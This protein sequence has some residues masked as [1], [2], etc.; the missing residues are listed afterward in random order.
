MKVKRNSPLVGGVK[1]SDGHTQ[2]SNG[3]KQNR[4]S[5]LK[6]RSGGTLISGQKGQKIKRNY[7]GN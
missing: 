2:R 3:I 4:E 1:D 6:V 7:L 5:S